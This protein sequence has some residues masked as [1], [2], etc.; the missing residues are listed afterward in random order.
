[1]RD[2]VRGA[3]VRA[4]VCVYIKSDKSEDM[5]VSISETYNIW[6]KLRVQISSDNF[7]NRET[8][9]S[10]VHARLHANNKHKYSREKD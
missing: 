8:F 4:R 1:M 6:E 10:I 7:M 5:C 2:C 9:V 3:R